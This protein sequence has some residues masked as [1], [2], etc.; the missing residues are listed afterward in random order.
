MQLN[1]LSGVTLWTILNIR[2]PRVK[3]DGVMSVAK[4]L[5]ATIM[6][7]GGA[8]VVNHS[9]HLEAQM[10][11]QLDV[12]QRVGGSDA[13]MQKLWTKQETASFRGEQG[14]L[15]ARARVHGLRRRIAGT[16]TSKESPVVQG[17]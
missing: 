16:Y 14:R 10:R 2:E 8:F 9:R 3:R 7:T 15:R 6:G 1:E 4:H 17:L 12:W 13:C 5:L 11:K